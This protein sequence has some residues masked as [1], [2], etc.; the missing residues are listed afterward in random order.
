MRR[1]REE[2]QPF[3]GLSSGSPPAPGPPSALDAADD[4]FPEPSPNRA[5]VLAALAI[6]D[7]ETD[8][9]L[10]GYYVQRAIAES[11][12]LVVDRLGD[13]RTPIT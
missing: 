12:L 5:N 7:D 8:L 1:R 4:D 2:E 3:A 9:D 10:A 13:P 11:L 6:A